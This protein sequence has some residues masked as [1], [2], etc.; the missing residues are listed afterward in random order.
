MGIFY[1]ND[2]GKFSVLVKR[3]K[4]RFSNSNDNRN[5]FMLTREREI[6]FLKH[7]RRKKRNEKSTYYFYYQLGVIYWHNI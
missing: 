5:D 4:R 1:S 2:N 6:V 7:Y 3:N